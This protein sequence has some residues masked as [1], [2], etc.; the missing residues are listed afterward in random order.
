[1]STDAQDPLARQIDDFERYLSSERR[2][3][4]RTVVT[5]GRDLRALA[6]YVREQGLTPDAGRLDVFVL[7]GFLA[8]L[9]GPN[10]PPTLARKIAAIRS[11]YRFLQRRGLI[12]HNPA[13]GLASPKMRR[14][15][16]RFLTV[17]VAT[18][19]VAA[20]ALDVSRSAALAA[21]DVAILEVLYGAGVRVGELVGL[22]LDDV[23]LGAGRARVLGKG[24]KERNVPIG[25]AASRAIGAYLKLRGGFRHPKTGA[26]EQAALFLGLRGT[27][28]S[29]RQV[30]NLVRRYGALAAGRGDL[31]PHALR[32]SCATHLLDAGADLRGIQEMLGHASL[33]TTQRYTHVTVDR[34]RE[35]YARAHPLAKLRGEG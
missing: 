26:Q 8:G 24:S 29:E 28:L 9:F 31:H 4:E 17:E 22:D 6:D 25:S 34:L 33:S 14:T 19:V 23:D 12:K 15:L 16:P 10:K 21:R 32:H 27:R 2:L 30:Q 35:V 11:F 5:Y 3:A 18:Q 13:A 7:R 1:V 20:P